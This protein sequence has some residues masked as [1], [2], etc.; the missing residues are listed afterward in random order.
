MGKEV[1]FSHTYIYMNPQKDTLIHIYKNI[2]KKCGVDI[3][4]TEVY[5]KGEFCEHVVR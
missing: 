1:V 2:N 5:N 3:K 4:I